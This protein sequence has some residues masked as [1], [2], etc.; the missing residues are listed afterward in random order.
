MLKD[1]IHD[2]L[3]PWV[4]PAFLDD[5]TEMMERFCARKVMECTVDAVCQFYEVDAQE[6][7]LTEVQPD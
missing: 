4:I 3:E 1:E 5:I 6:Q 7:K 2:M